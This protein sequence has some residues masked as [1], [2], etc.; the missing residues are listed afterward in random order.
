MIFREK[1]LKSEMIYRGRILNLRR[2]TVTVK[3]GTSTREIVEHHGGA[4]IAAVTA[5]GR[6]IMV[7]QFRKPVERVVLEV[8]AGKRE[9]GE[10]PR[11]TAVRELKEETGYTAGSMELLTAMETSVGYTT[12]VLYVYLATDLVPGE[13]AF[14]ENEALDIV[15]FDLDVMYDKAVRGELRDAKTIVAVTLAKARL[16]A[17]K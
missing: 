7:R 4:V 12:E 11:E 15:D 9:E 13:T 3:N 17:R 16:A 2:D 1:T 10:D 14:D 8:P 5:E 6:I